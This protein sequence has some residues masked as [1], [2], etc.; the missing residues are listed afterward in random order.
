MHNHSEPNWKCYKKCLPKF[1]EVFRLTGSTNAVRYPPWN[2]L[3]VPKFPG[4]RQTAFSGVIML[5][6]ER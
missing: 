1:T 4:L 2:F 6:E 5:P 3:S